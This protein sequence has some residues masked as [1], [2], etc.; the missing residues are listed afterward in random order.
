MKLIKKGQNPAT[1]VWTG[2]CSKCRSVFE[3]FESEL[4]K[5]IHSQ[6]DGPFSWEK[7]PECGAGDE[8]RGNWGGVCFEPKYHEQ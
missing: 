7:C 3:A 8:S 6:R 2:N 1:R 4:T 5:I